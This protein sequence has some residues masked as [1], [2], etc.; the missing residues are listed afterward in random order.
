M[1]SNSNFNLNYNLHMIT[2]LFSLFS[3]EDD[4]EQF[5]PILTAS[6]QEV[7]SV[8]TETA[9]ESDSRLCYLVASIAN[10]RYTEIHGARENCL[11]TY[12]GTVSRESDG[13]QRLR[14]AQK[15]VRS[16][17]GLCRDL[18]RDSGA[19]LIATRG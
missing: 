3:G 6:I 14:F 13:A 2:S 7:R 16:Y 9:D 19:F 1:A 12:A 5:L 10:L 15:L 18:L 4:P 11:A 8:L 17:Q